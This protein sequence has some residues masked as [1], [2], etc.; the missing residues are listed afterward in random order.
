MTTRIAK[1]N[2]NPKLKLKLKSQSRTDERWTAQTWYKLAQHYFGMSGD[3]D[4]PKELRDHFDAQAEAAWITGDLMGGI[5]PEMR[6]EIT[7][8]EVEAE[9]AW[10]RGETDKSPSQLDEEAREARLALYSVRNREKKKPAKS[11]TNKVARASQLQL[12][13]A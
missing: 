7:R 13:L 10:S 3:R 5:T 1:T 11:K 12:K 2:S 6:A 4:L 8:K 9:A